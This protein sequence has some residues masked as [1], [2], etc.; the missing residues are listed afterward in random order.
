MAARK[1]APVDVV[2]ADE[3]EETARPVLDGRD[4]NLSRMRIVGTNADIVKKITDGS[5][6][7]G[8]IMVGE[9]SDDEDSIFVDALDGKNAVRFYVLSVHPN[10]ACK[11]GGPK[12]QWEEGDPEMPAEARRQYN[13]MLFCPEIDDSF[14]ILY[15]AGGT[16]AREVRKINRR[17]LLAD[18][19]DL[20]FS[21]HTIMR[22][23][24]DNVWP[25]PVFQLDKP[26]PAESA[27]AKAMRDQFVGGL[28]PRKALAAGS[29]DK[30]GF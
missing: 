13:Y 23:G 3:I 14:P 6:R 30:P 26:D 16:A 24:G 1:D 9:D 5:V 15:T 12:G 22:H 10:Y 27:A 29:S 28:Q 7:P 18:P 4:I 11:F 17:F 19:T 20:C 25:G 21:V 8:F 2:D